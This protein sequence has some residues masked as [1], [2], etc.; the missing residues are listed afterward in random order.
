MGIP[1]KKM[2]E[3]IITD[4]VADESA[5]KATPEESST[6][7]TKEQSVPYHRF[8]E[9]NQKYGELK[10]Q[11]SELQAQIKEKGSTTPEES[12]AKTYLKQMLKE[13]LAEEQRQ[14]QQEERAVQEKFN[15]SLDEVL[16]IHTDVKR[17]DFIKFIEDNAKKFDI[18]SVQGAMSLYK[19]MKSSKVVAKTDKPNLPE[20]KGTAE[21][22]P[23][24][25]DKGKSLS[26]I[27]EEAI[28]D[29]S[30]KK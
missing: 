2:E 24:Y 20:H 30:K 1:R 11:I 13:T 17:A 21:S 14:K 6:P 3:Q 19:E 10:E 4:A 12:N 29:L 5:E 8:K 15:N 27:A 22:K 23:V 9:V 7:E 26:Q 18:S 16:D 25:D 28:A